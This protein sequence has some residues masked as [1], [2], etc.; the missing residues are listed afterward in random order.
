MSWMNGPC[1]PEPGRGL[2]ATRYEDDEIIT[3][4]GEVVDSRRAAKIEREW[5]ILAGESVDLD[6]WLAKELDDWERW[7]REGPFGG[8]SPETDGRT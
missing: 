5:E 7:R 3:A 2:P 1:N 6:V 8:L 4:I